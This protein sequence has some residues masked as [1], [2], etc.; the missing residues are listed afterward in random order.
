MSPSHK[1]RIY[2]YTYQAPH[3]PELLYH[4]KLT[5]LFMFR[6]AYRVLVMYRRRDLWGLSSLDFDPHRFLDSRVHEY[7]TPN[8]L[9][10]LLF[11]TGLRICQG[12]Q[13]AYHEALFLVRLL[14]RF[15][16]I[17]LVEE[18]M[19]PGGRVPKE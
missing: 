18:A 3:A 5:H 19:P 7:S 15:G 2:A 14:Q 17:K 12:Q 11:N 8:P 13:F 16:R 10:F 4:P 9:I 6:C 1:A